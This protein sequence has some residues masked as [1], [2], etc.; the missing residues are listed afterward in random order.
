LQGGRERLSEDR[1]DAKGS[2]EVRRNGFTYDPLGAIVI[3]EAEA[4]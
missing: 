1:L 2:E 4:V 3:G